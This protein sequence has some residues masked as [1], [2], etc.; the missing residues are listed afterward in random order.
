MCRSLCFPDLFPLSPKSLVTGEGW[1]GW[2]FGTHAG[3]CCLERLHPDAHP[4]GLWLLVNNSCSGLPQGL[5]GR[6]CARWK[7]GGIP[8]G[9]PW[10]LKTRG[11]FPG[12]NLCCLLFFQSRGHI[13]REFGVGLHQLTLTAV[14]ILHSFSPW[15]IRPYVVCPVPGHSAAA[16]TELSSD[17]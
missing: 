10:Q 3:F 9:I 7:V 13:K 1:L 8:G 14:I 15:H 16:V 5:R 2:V 12:P 4:E 17:R 6:L 11:Q